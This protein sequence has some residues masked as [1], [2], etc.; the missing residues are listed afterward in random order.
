A[1]VFETARGGIL[2]EGLGF[3]RCDVAVVTNLGVGDHLGM[4]FIT[5]SDGLA[6]VKRV[7]VQNVAP[8]GAAVL[9]A[10]D[11]MVLKMADAC[12]GSVVL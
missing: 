5:S 1:A 11:P 2:R 3:D 4:N 10:M 9:N 7:I 8:T 12:P 6:L